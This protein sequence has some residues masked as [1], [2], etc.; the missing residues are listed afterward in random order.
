MFEI[1]FSNSAFF[2]LSYPPFREN[3]CAR[4]FCWGFFSEKN[5]AV[6]WLLEFRIRATYTDSVSIPVILENFVLPRYYH[7]SHMQV[8]NITYLATTK[9]SSHESIKV[10]PT[11]LRI[12]PRKISQNLHVQKNFQTKCNLAKINLLKEILLT[13]TI[14]NTT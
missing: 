5:N 14:T 7:N 6:Y 8:I 1:I 9:I 10:L 3:N 2:G 12:N 13:F 11:L 4:N